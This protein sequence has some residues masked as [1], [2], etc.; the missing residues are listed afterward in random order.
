MSSINNYEI[1]VQ[2][3]K[4]VGSA[5]RRTKRAFLQHGSIPIY[6]DRALLNS[7]FRYKFNG[8]RARSME[9]LKNKVITLS[10]CL[11]KDVAC[12]EVCKALKKGFSRVLSGRWTQES[13]SPSEKVGYK[14][15]F[16]SKGIASILT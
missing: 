13:L 7:L 14:S 16:S 4:L 2:G 8:S 12:E 15:H 9:I 1:E 6:C 3:A 10:E 5:Q 11:G